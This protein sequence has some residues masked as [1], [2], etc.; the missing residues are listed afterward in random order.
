MIDVI[1][2][3]KTRV[4]AIRIIPFQARKYAITG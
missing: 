1:D 3:A 2:K 4:Y